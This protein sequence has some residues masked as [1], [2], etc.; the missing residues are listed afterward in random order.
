MLRVDDRRVLDGIFWMLRTGSPWRNLPERHGPYTTVYN[1]FNREAKAGVWVQVLETLA[2][3]PTDS[4][5]FIDS[6]IIQAHQQAAAKREADHTL[7]RSRGGLTI[8]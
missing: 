4:M 2:E 7:G 8:T 1:R 5:Q 6:S 3:K